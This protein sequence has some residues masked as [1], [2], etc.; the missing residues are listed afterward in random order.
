MTLTIHLV[1]ESTVHPL[2]QSSTG[3]NNLCENIPSA[4]CADVLMGHLPATMQESLSEWDG[5]WDD[6]ELRWVRTGCAWSRT[7]KGTQSSQ[8]D[9]ANTW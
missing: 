6:L 1:S 9:V 7:P 4:G 2:S 8:S 3:R 5:V